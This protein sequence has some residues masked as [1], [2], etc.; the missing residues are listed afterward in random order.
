MMH[1]HLVLGRGTANLDARDVPLHRRAVVPPRAALQQLVTTPVRTRVDR[2]QVDLSTGGPAE[3]QR[4]R[5]P[6]PDDLVAVG[7]EQLLDG[8]HVVAK[9]NEVHVSVRPGLLA[10][11][12]V[13]APA[14]VEPVDNSQAVQLAQQAEDV[15]RLHTSK[16]AIQPSPAHQADR[17]ASCSPTGGGTTQGVR[18]R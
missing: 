1:S 9:E 14:A 10:Q 18:G 4:C 6:I 11:Q 7:F 3:R 12:T 17:G 15:R 16:P 2:V 8:G 13:N 5:Q